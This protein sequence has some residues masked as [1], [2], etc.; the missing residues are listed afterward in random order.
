[1]GDSK[2]VTMAVFTVQNVRTASGGIVFLDGYWASPGEVVKGALM[3]LC[4][5]RPPDVGYI[6]GVSGKAECC[7]DRQTQQPEPFRRRI[8]SPSEV[9]LIYKPELPYQEEDPDRPADT[10]TEIPF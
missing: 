1:M 7:I 5:I 3:W 2:L 6:L 4:K 10:G 8:K 9:I